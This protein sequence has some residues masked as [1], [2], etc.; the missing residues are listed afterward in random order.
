MRAT[1]GIKMNPENK[2]RIPD[3]IRYP[4]MVVAILGLSVLSQVFLFRAAFS[5]G[6]A[7]IE[8]DYYTRAV[9][10]DAAQK[11][12]EAR[13]ALGWRVTAAAQTGD[14]IIEVA[15]RAGAPVTGLRGAVVAQRA[16]RAKAELPAGLQPVGPGRYRAAVA[17]ADGVWDLRVTLE[18]TTRPGAKVAPWELRLEPADKR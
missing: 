16:D 1:K 10:W 6:G 14:V 3:H 5:N 7:Q 4:G 2:R 12:R 18:D 11:M 8:R 9:G 13:E 15:D 17:A